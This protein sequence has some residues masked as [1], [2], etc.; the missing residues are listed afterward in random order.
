MRKK[1]WSRCSLYYITPNKT[2]TTKKTRNY[3]Q[4]KYMNDYK[5]LIMKQTHNYCSTLI[6][7]NFCK[8]IGMAKSTNISNDI[9]KILH[10]IMICQGMTT[11][12][13]NSKVTKRKARHKFQYTKHKVCKS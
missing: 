7:R 1:I 4:N 11:I 3:I 5:L 8:I 10:F 12:L 9:M 2:K 6:L 13:P